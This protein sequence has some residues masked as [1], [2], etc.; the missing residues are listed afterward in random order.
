MTTSPIGRI[1]LDLEFALENDLEVDDSGE[2]HII[3]LLFGS[4][5]DEVV[6]EGRTSFEEVVS[7]LLDFYRDDSSTPSTTGAGQL[8]AIA[9]RMARHVEDLKSLANYL[10]GDHDPEDYD[11]AIFGQ[12]L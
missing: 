10:E 5:G 9:D 6:F 8:R 1:G 12:P 3:T 11:D 4:S 2:L 7:N